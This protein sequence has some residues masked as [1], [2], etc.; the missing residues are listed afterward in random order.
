MLLHG[1]HAR[2]GRQLTRQ[3]N[4][5]DFHQETQRPRA[6]RYILGAL[7]ESECESRPRP[8]PLRLYKGPCYAT[9]V[10]DYEALVDFDSTPVGAQVTV[11]T[12]CRR[13]A[14]VAARDLL[15][16][17]GNTVMALK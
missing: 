4:L 17:R 12:R 13:A 11:A 8:V 16:Q 15:L 2:R 3:E 1:C 7:S 5:E 10:E 6:Y 14:R 9:L